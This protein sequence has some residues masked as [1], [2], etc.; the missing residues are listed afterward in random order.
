MNA[1]ILV[2]RIGWGE[3]L[4]LKFVFIH[5]LKKHKV[6]ESWKAT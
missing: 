1:M 5:G 2:H 6:G 3:N 4:N